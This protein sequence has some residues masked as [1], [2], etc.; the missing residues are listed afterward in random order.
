MAPFCWSQFPDLIALHCKRWLVLSRW[1]KTVRRREF[2][3]GLAGSAAWP[4]AARAQQPAIPTIDFL[5][6]ESPAPFAHLA[7]AFRQGLSETGY[8]EGRN[9]TI[10]YRWAEGHYERLPELAADLVHHAV[11]VI[12]ASGGEP[13]ALAAKGATKAIPI[14]FA[15]GEDPV[16]LGLVESFNRPGGNAT[17][18]TLLAYS[19]ATKRWEFLRELLSS[20]TIAVLAKSDSSSSQFELKELRA[21][22][23]SLGQVVNVFNASDEREIDAAFGALVQQRARGLLVTTEALF[24]NRRNQIISLAAAHSIPT[25]YPFREFAAVPSRTRLEFGGAIS[26]N[27][28]LSF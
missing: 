27:M 23:N 7:G 15:A 1:E 3:A 17:G 22:A 10:E 26:G 12:V 28:R 9:V 16:A 2:I 20:A 13:A 24:T 4:L 18:I 6:I 8:V 11:G 21:A 14:V 5:N 19:A 25:I